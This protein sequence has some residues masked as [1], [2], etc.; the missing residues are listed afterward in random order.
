ML[1]GMTRG[2]VEEKTDFSREG[3]KAKVGRKVRAVSE[4]ETG[5]SAAD[6]ERIDKNY[7]ALVGCFCS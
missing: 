4:S 7:E 1:V 2:G 5:D 6:W 3:V